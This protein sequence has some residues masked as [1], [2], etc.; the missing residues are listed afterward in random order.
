MSHLSQVREL[1][2]IHISIKLIQAVSH[3]SQVR[4]LKLLF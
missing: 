1:K 4:E 2:L 3:L